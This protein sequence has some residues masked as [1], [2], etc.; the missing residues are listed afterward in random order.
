MK[1]GGMG[2]PPEFVRP[3]SYQ[4]R[5][6]D[7][8]ESVARSLGVE[9]G[10]LARENNLPAGGELKAGMD[11]ILPR[12]AAA[13][14]DRG[15]AQAAGEAIG[16]TPFGQSEIAR[17]G[18]KELAEMVGSPRALLLAQSP[19][20]D[21]HPGDLAAAKLAPAMDENIAA[22]KLA[23]F[24]GDEAAAKLAPAMDENIA[25]KV[26]PASLDKEAAEA[27]NVQQKGRKG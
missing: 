1:I 5:A 19:A 14:P 12:Q 4:V 24:H 18:Q 11:L 7:T 26:R 20:V 21:L 10:A 6:G 15:W 22:A 8:L 25:A 17:H 23:P 2:E 3:E 27:Q 13:I 9:P 16:N